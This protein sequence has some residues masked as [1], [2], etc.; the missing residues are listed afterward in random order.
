M[1]CLWVILNNVAVGTK[2]ENTR[3]LNNTVVYLLAQMFRRSLILFSWRGWAF[4]PFPAA[5]WRICAWWCLS[6]DCVPTENSVTVTHQVIDPMFVTR[7]YKKIWT[8]DSN[9]PIVTRW[10]SPGALSSAVLNILIFWSHFLF[11]S[12]LFFSYFIISWCFFH[13][14]L[15]HQNILSIKHCFPSTLSPYL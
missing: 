9:K 7:L 3:K 8:H 15:F 4:G 13:S 1:S 5:S 14:I 2:T 12:R 11:I 6:F 10:I